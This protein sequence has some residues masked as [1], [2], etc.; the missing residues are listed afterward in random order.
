MTHLD[1][2]G[3][4]RYRACAAVSPAAGFGD[5]TYSPRISLRA[6]F[7]ALVRPIQWAA[8]VG[9]ASALPVREYRFANPA[10]RRPPRLATGSGIANA[11]HEGP[12]S[13][14]T[15]RAQRARQSRIPVLS[16]ST[17]TQGFA[18]KGAA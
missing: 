12:M 4:G 7:A 8:L 11:T 6:A 13:Q 9:R 18:G 3:M 5:L 17:T 15:T 2:T 16:A 14:S 10:L 1:P